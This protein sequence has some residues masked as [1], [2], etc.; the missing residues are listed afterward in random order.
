MGYLRRGLTLQELKKWGRELAKKGGSARDLALMIVEDNYSL[1]IASIRTGIISESSRAAIRKWARNLPEKELA[2]FN[3]YIRLCYNVFNY[4]VPPVERAYRA[5]DRNATIVRY[6]INRITQV[7][8]YCKLANHLS[9]IL[10]AKKEDG[11]FSD[12]EEGVE[13]DLKDMREA[14]GA[15]YF[16]TEREDGTIAPLYQKLWAMLNY[17]SGRLRYNVRELLTYQAV[18]ERLCEDKDLEDF[19][20][21]YLFSLID[22]LKEPI[23]DKEDSKYSELNAL[24]EEEKLRQMEKENSPEDLI[25]EQTELYLDMRKYA[26]VPDID[27]T[28][29]QVQQSRVRAIIMNIQDTSESRNENR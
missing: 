22:S 11:S 14:I 16:S 26:V 5:F 4:L 24:R 20:P 12:Y 1:S 28:R 10:K 27:R 8:K 2:I 17:D 18:V 7:E 3:H 25:K 9:P 23:L 13:Q 29:E 6:H 21:D 15:P 19:L